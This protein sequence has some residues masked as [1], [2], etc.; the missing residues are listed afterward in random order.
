MSVKTSQKEGAGMK[1]FG[2]PLKDWIILLTFLGFGTGAAVSIGG[3]P[4]QTRQAITEQTDTLTV[5]I[6]RLTEAIRLN[7]RSAQINASRIE[8]HKRFE[9]DIDQRLKALE[10][11]VMEG[12]KNL[13]GYFQGRAD[14]YKKRNP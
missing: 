9:E 14:E 2:Y 6:D 13:D 8:D 4:G 12:L 10:G 7:T 11:T 3:T 1:I 5:Q